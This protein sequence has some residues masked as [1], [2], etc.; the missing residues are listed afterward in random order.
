MLFKDSFDTFDIIVEVIVKKL[1]TFDSTSQDRI[2]IP[3][4]PIPKYYVDWE[5]AFTE[6]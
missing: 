4:A 6:K 3:F 1:F 2:T 5:L